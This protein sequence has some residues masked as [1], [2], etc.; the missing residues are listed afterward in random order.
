MIIHVYPCH[1]MS[2]HVICHH[3]TML[4]KSVLANSGHVGSGSGITVATVFKNFGTSSRECANDVNFAWTAAEYSCQD[5]PG[6]GNCW[7]M[8]KHFEYYWIIMKHHETYRNWASRAKTPETV[9]WT[10][11]LQFQEPE[12]ELKQTDPTLSWLVGFLPKSPLAIFANQ[13]GTRALRLSHES[14][15]LPWTND[16]PLFFS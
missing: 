1:Y 16:F 2:F 10:E 4:H 5:G 3:V 7:N 14:A 13:A 6:T 12:T 9:S 8:L 11:Y 15:V